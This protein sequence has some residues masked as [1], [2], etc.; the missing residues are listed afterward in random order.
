MVMTRPPGVYMERGPARAP[1]LGLLPS[2]VPAFLGLAERGPTSSPLAIRSMEEFY[3]RFGRLEV[4]NYL[5]ASLDG[6]FLN[7]GRE[8]YVVRIAHFFERGRRDIATK[9]SG[10]L[11]DAQRQNTLQVQAMSEGMWGNGVRVS[12]IHKPAAVQTLLTV[13]ARVGDTTAMVKSTY[14]FGRGTLVKISDGEQ[15]AYRV[16]SAVEGR[17]LAWAEREPLDRPFL[18]SAPTLIEPVGFDLIAETHHHKEV[19]AD[20]NLSRQSPR[21][22]E[23]VING[24]SQLIEVTSLTR[25]RLSPT[26]FRSRSTSWL[27]KVG[28]TACTPCRQR[29]FWAPTT[30]PV[31]ATVWR[32]WPN[33]KKSIW[34]SCPT[35]RGVSSAAVG[36]PK[37]WRSCNKRLWTCVNNAVI[38]L[39]F[40]TCLLA[41]RPRVP[42]SG[43]GFLTAAMRL[44]ITRMSWHPP[45]PSHQPWRPGP[46]S[47]SSRWVA[48]RQLAGNSI[49]CAR[50]ATRRP[51]C[52]GRAGR[53]RR[54]ATWPASTLVVT[55]NKGCFGPPANEPLQG[56]VDLEWFLAQTDQA[57]LNQEGINCLAVFAH[58][59]IR[60]WGART[61][62]SDPMLRFV[63]VRRTISA[64]ARALHAGLQWVVF[65][66]NG[67]DLWQLVEAD[68]R[69]FLEELWRR[70]FLQGATAADAFFVRCDEANNTH[71]VRDA[72]QLV[73]DVGISPF[74]PAEFVGVRV[75]QELDVLARE[76]GK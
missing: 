34:W 5:A 63:N 26:S 61:A 47:I 41:P 37:T 14:G 9:A 16:L 35:C 36:R 13:D 30:V 21:F 19:F 18:S 75:V 32:V 44:F 22:A 33:W 70:G 54:L 15:T 55:A 40:W 17:L 76:D 64:I 71:E 38:V 3:N 50:P 62:A 23:R 48:V 67:P 74:R 25:R 43:G 42:C 6:F 53:F 39:P 28:R 24:I 60:V 27:W 8:A 45:A 7:G 56:V 20:L 1:A 31:I 4:G 52:W 68:V 66:N 51:L 58:R 72:G 73:L 11:R 57:M 59:G 29:T 69:Y 46:T 49:G 10:R 2:G 65:E 12:V